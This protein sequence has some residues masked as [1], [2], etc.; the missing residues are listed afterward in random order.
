MAEEEGTAVGSE[1]TVTKSVQTQGAEFG[2]TLESPGPIEATWNNNNNFNSCG[3]VSDVDREKKLE[4]ADELTD[5]RSKAFK[6]NDFAEAADCFS[7]ALEIR[8]GH[9]G[10]LAI[11]CLK[12]YYLYGRALLY[13]A[14]EEADPLVSVPKEGET[15]QESNKYEPSKSA[16][17]REL[18]V[19]SV[20]SSTT[21]DEGGKDEEGSDDSDNE[22]EDVDESDLDLA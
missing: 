20:S 12:A 3:I 17:S 11:D 15:Q 10:E 18:S 2:G 1:V 8:V 13:K 9:H 5:K 19:A 7:R 22:A 14:Q 4:F 6:E 21:L 16:L